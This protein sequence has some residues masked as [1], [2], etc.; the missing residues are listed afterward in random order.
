[1]PVLLLAFTSCLRAPPKESSRIDLQLRRHDVLV[2]RVD[3][4]VRTRRLELRRR[5]HFRM[6][7]RLDNDPDE[8]LGEPPER[9]CVHVCVHVDKWG[10]GGGSER[11]RA[12]V[13]L[14]WWGLGGEHTWSP[15]PKPPPTALPMSVQRRT[16]HVCWE[17]LGCTSDAN[18]PALIQLAHVRSEIVLVVLLA[19]LVHAAE[20]ACHPVL[21]VHRATREDRQQ[22]AVFA[23]SLLSRQRQVSDLASV[24]LVQAALYAETMACLRMRG[25]RGELARMSS[26]G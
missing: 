5:L 4:D 7:V 1:M 12:S 25:S 6:V 19:I 13:C 26:D 15:P 9:V 11:V 3:E 17:V 10:R 20:D 24:L 18:G 8:E 22:N 16:P 14:S 23:K 21:L 2:Q